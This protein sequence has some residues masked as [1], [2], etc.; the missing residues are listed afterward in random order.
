MHI[1][2][3]WPDAPGTPPP[4][5]PAGQTALSGLQDRVV[6]V[7]CVMKFPTGDEAYALVDHAIPDPPGYYG[8]YKRDLVRRFGAVSRRRSS[9]RGAVSYYGMESEFDDTDGHFRAK[10]DAGVAFGGVPIEYWAYSEATRLAQGTPWMLAKGRM[11]EP[12]HGDDFGFVLR[13]DDPLNEL[14]D[15]EIPKN[16]IG[17]VAFPGLGRENQPADAIGKGVP[18]VGG[19]HDVTMIEP[20]GRARRGE[21]GPIP[22]IALDEQFVGS[23]NYRRMLVSG[24]TTPVTRVFSGG[25]ERTGHADVLVPGS[26]PWVAAGLGTNLTQLMADGHRYYYFLV[27][28]GSG[29]ERGHM[30]GRAPITVCVQGASERTAAAGVPD[31]LANLGAPI[32][33]IA[34]F[35]LWLLKQHGF[36]HKTTD[37][38]EADPEW[39][40]GEPLLDDASFTDTDVKLQSSLPGGFPVSFYLAE[41]TALSKVLADLHVSADFGTAP[42]RSGKRI[43]WTFDKAAYFAAAHFDVDAQRPG[44][45]VDRRHDE[46]WNK[47]VYGFGKR[48]SRQQGL[49]IVNADVVDDASVAKYGRRIESSQ[50]DF[51]YLKGDT[52][53][54]TVAPTLTAIAGSVTPGVHLLALGYGEP[55]NG[56]AVG[57]TSQITVAS[58]EGVRADNLQV[59]DDPLVAVKTIYM[60]KAGSGEID[61]WWVITIPNSQTSYDVVFPDG[62]LNGKPKAPA[63]DTGYPNRAMYNAARRLARSSDT[64]RA[65]SVPLNSLDGT[66]VDVCGAFAVTNQAGPSAAGYDRALVDVAEHVTDM[67]ALATALSGLDVDHVPASVVFSQ[68][69]PGTQERPPEFVENVDPSTGTGPIPG[70]F[71]QYSLGG[72]HPDGTLAAASNTWYEIPLSRPQPFNRED[73]GRRRLHLAGPVWTEGG[74]TA[75]LALFKKGALGTVLAATWSTSADE[76]AP[77]AL[78]VWLSGEYLAADAGNSYAAMYKV[79]DHTKRVHG[80]GFQ[81]ELY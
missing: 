47:V 9:D 20:R 1:I 3:L 74:M 34:M 40:A 31:T 51:P 8:G 69:S 52:P 77:A 24:D 39:T 78:D 64:P 42:T 55:H 26:S 21:W 61:L 41:P 75:T 28:V 79:S 12:S 73:V 17:T 35:T 63:L 45:S 19:M 18:I 5:P 48:Y 57:P 59:S 60:S 58:G 6:H 13:A 2:L 67:D 66:S 46:R 27:R 16:R 23:V 22:V 25:E 32:T 44:F 50:F 72:F 68:D 15:V 53:R 76:A 36:G 71:A 62:E 14:L 30:D 56:T 70:P 33:S 4:P 7:F 29:I 38:W 65:V 37:D 10:L 54:P 80:P 49:T 11:L 43:A 81:L